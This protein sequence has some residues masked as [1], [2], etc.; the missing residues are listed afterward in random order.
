MALTERQREALQQLDDRH[1]I[2][3][4][5]LKAPKR[6]KRSAD[7]Y[8]EVPACTVREQNQMVADAKRKRP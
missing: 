5:D 1:G 4:T 2:D 3:A 7:G 6:G 8:W